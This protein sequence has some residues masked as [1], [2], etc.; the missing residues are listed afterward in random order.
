MDDLQKEYARHENGLIDVKL[1]IICVCNA[2]YTY[3]REL[4]KPDTPI[5]IHC[6]NCHKDYNLTII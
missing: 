2:K 3:T 6:N 4:F 5:T 1:E